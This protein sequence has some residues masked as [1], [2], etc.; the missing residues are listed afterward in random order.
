[1][2]SAYLLGVAKF[3]IGQHAKINQI[4][5]YLFQVGYIS[6]APA[7]QNFIYNICTQM[8]R[9]ILNQATNREFNIFLNIQNM[10][11]ICVA[12]V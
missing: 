2:L 1:M 12:P 4:V 6:Q 3:Q 11:N 8:N 9:K 10:P 5:V 7:M